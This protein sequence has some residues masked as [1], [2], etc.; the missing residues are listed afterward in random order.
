MKTK[1]KQIRQLK[2]IRKAFEDS[3]IIKLTRYNLRLELLEV[4]H[5]KNDA[6]RVGLTK[7]VA[8]CNAVRDPTKQLNFGMVQ[9][10]NGLVFSHLSVAKFIAIA[11]L[12][13]RL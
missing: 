10:H 3:K 5:V 13:P 8:T 6:I 9:R 4:R 2:R 12:N 7:A 11:K 1:L